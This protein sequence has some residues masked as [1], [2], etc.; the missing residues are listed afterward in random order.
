MVIDASNDRAN[1]LEVH[2]LEHGQL[3]QSPEPM[4]DQEK[5]KGLERAFLNWHLL[6]TRN[7]LV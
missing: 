6:T 2:R 4:V 1:G 3:G 5:G 7:F